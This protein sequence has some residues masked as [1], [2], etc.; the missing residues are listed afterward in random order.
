MPSGTM[1]GSL[2]RI[3]Q[4]FKSISTHEYILGIRQRNWKPFIGR[5]WQRNYY[6]HVIRDENDLNRVQKYIINNP[7]RWLSDGEK[8][9]EA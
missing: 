1:P 8:F 3:I 9:D 2:G 7:L 5:L 6:E 4:A